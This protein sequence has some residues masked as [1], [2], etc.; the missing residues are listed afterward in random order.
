M[1]MHHYI[2]EES[3]YSMIKWFKTTSQNKNHTFSYI[4]NQVFFVDNF[5]QKFNSD[6]SNNYIDYLQNIYITVFNAILYTP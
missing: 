5:N 4:L 3:F 2:W 1:S 6:K